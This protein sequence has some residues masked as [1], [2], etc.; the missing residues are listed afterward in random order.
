MGAKIHWEKWLPAA[1]KAFIPFCNGALPCMQARLQPTVAPGYLK[2]AKLRNDMVYQRKF[3][4][5]VSQT[6]MGVFV[7]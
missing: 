1:P 6:A 4:K 3:I 2:P 5:E 7:L